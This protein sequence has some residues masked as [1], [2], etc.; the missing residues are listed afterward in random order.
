MKKQYYIV[1]QRGADIAVLSGPLEPYPSAYL[2]DLPYG[3]AARL[4]NI[5]P[6]LVALI[7][8]IYSPL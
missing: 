3:I 2:T 6:S 1:P 8:N 4:F 7:N 5:P